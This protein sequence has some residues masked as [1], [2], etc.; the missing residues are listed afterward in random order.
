MKPG[1]EAV[2]WDNDGVLV[3]TEPLYLRA[4]QEILAGIGIELTVDAFREVSLRRG[5]SVFELAAERG[6]TADEVS[7]LRAER[8][9]RYAELLDE[10]V[11]VLDGVHESLEILRGRLPMAIVTSSQRTHFDRIHR[12]TSLLDYFEFVLANGDYDRHKP[13]PDPYLA[14]AE[15]LG[16]APER[17]LA[18]EDTERGLRS[19]VAAGMRC[20]V[21]PRELSRASDF[22]SAHRIL[23]TAR[24][25]ALEV[26]VLLGSASDRGSRRPDAG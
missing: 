16:V 26:D 10:G 24:D 8:D 11:K 3:D 15:R 4:N 7:R 19:A 18:I 25:V 9:R 6:C 2:L 1:L 23:E 21:I 14:A 5:R 20:L 22:T 13:H 17:C 12:Q